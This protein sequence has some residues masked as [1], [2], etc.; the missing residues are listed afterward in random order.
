LEKA[1]RHEKSADLARNKQN[2]STS[3]LQPGITAMKRSEIDDETLMAF[4]DGEL[5]AAT[6][7]EVLEAVAQDESLAT[8]LAVMADTRKLA[9]AAFAPML[10]EPVPDQLRAKV[11][12]MLAAKRAETGDAQH[13][14]IVKLR[15]SPAN[16]NPVRRWRDMAVAACLAFVVGGGIGWQAAGLATDGSSAGPS[17]FASLARA[18]VSDALS[19]VTS[20]QDIQLADGGRFK[21]IATFKSADDELCREFELDGAD[22]QAVVSVA[23]RRAETWDVRFAVAS[24]Q[25]EEGYA[26]ASSLETLQAYLTQIEAGAPMPENEERVA[27]G[28]EP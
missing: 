27:L 17:A 23:C 11:E 14:N 5:D 22:K 15:P 6:S 18:D 13:T 1:A 12:N 19:S 8:R 7:N 10:T 26:P 4:A 9:K 16:D 2:G 20:G 28:L 24:A 3:S 25:T 21:A